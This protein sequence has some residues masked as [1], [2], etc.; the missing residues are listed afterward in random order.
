M[1]P[2]GH[3][4]VPLW[5]PPSF[6][7]YANQLIR[8][9]LQD[10]D[11]TSDRG[12]GGIVALVRKE[13]VEEYKGTKPFIWTIDEITMWQLLDR[14]LDESVQVLFRFRQSY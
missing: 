7:D 5:I 14:R 3:Q 2:D 8:D 12:M 9:V 10:N 1:T 13:N 6:A 4:R 11:L